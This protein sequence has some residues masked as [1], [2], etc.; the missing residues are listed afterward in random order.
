MTTII[1]NTEAAAILPVI[2]R[3]TAASCLLGSGSPLAPSASWRGTDVRGTDVRGTDVFGGVFAGTGTS[4][5]SERPTQAPM[6]EAAQTLGYAAAANG[7]GHRIDRANGSRTAVTKQ[8]RSMR[9]FRGLEPW[10]D[11]A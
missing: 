11:P 2:G 3:P 4:G 8:Y 6:A 5:V 10:R 1:K 7:A 9:A